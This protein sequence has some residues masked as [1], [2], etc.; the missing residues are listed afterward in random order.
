MSDVETGKPRTGIA[1]ID[2]DEDLRKINFE[3]SSLYS[4]YYEFDDYISWQDGME[5]DAFFTYE[6][7]FRSHIENALK[8]GDLAFLKR[9]ADFIEG[10][11]LTGD[12]D[13]MNVVYVGVL[14]GLK[15]NCNNRKVHTF[16]KPAIRK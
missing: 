5:T 12:N 11:Y 2:N 3:I 4:S 15:A 1:I 7:V 6:D 10:L 9:A 8:T 14:E 13:A 16:L